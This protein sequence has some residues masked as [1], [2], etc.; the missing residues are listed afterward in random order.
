MKKMTM[1]LMLAATLLVTKGFSQ[2]TKEHSEFHGATANLKAYR[3]L[4]ILNNSDEKK[5][6]ATLRNINNAL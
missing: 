4:Y 1:V 2:S 3:A 5:I 6:K